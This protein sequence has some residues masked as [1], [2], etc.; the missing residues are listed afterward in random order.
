MVDRFFYWLRATYLETHRVAYW[1]ANRM[2][3]SERPLQEKVALFWHGHFAV[4]ETKVRDYRKMLRQLE[5]FQK[6]GTGDFRDLLIAVSQDPAMLAFLDAGQNV[7]GAP[8]E[9]FAREIMELF[10][11]GRRATT[12]SSDIRE[13]AR[14]FTG[15]NYR[16]PRLR[17]RPRASTTPTRRRCSARRGPFDGVEVIDIILASA[18]VTADFIAA[19]LYRYLGA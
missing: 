2:L 9:N 4:N 14:A 7:K 10:T 8:N 3:R 18:G 11:H 6:Q 13:A 5:L 1:W 12:A 19:K 15:W 16:R 17:G